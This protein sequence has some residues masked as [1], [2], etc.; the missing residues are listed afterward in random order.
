MASNRIQFFSV[1]VKTETNCY[2]S[3]FGEKKSNFMQ[4]ILKLFEKFENNWNESEIQCKFVFTGYGRITPALTTTW[5]PYSANCPKQTRLRNTSRP[6]SPSTHSIREPI[7]I[8]PTYTGG[9][10]P[11]F[12]QLSIIESSIPSISCN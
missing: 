11:L 4:K 8:W 5:A 6:L 10:P 9:A 7:S 12:A 2:L 1:C 3:G